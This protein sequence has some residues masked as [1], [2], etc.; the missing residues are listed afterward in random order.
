MK[1]LFFLLPVVIFIINSCEIPEVPADPVGSIRIA[2]EAEKF[3][4][5]GP[6][7]FLPPSNVPGPGVF[8]SDPTEKNQTTAV[9]WCP[10]ILVGNPLGPETKNG[11]I[12]RL[13]L[14]GVEN[15]T[16]WHEYQ[17][18][19]GNP[20]SGYPGFLWEGVTY[21]PLQTYQ[22]GFVCYSLVYRAILDAGFNPFNIL[23]GS[24]NSLTNRLVGPNS[25][26][27]QTGDIVAYDFDL[28]GIYDHLGILVNIAGQNQNDWLVVSS[29]GLVEIFEYGAK[30]RRL[31][32]FGTINGGE[33][34]TWNPNWE[35]WDKDFFY[36]NTNN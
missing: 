15:Q 19:M 20:P 25:G 22:T 14:A 31:G 13:T 32:V 5:D 24:C 21:Y 3:L 30:K 33:F 10:T 9:A 29:I 12:A 16:S 8:G 2:N 27:P 28:D 35:N 34:S 1:K 7:F 26:D 17:E 18:E 4:Y 23:P 6:D 36:V 11:Y